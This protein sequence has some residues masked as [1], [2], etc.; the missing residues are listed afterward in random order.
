M[1]F[2][3]YIIPKLFKCIDDY[4]IP[5]GY[6]NWNCTTLNKN[7]NGNFW[8]ITGDINIRYSLSELHKLSV[9]LHEIGHAFYYK[10]YPNCKSKASIIKFHNTISENNSIFHNH[11]ERIADVLGWKILLRLEGEQELK[12]YYV[13]YF[14][15]RK[16][17]L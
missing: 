16:D 7:V 4:K 6:V 8:A 11:D 13:N 15:T 5:F 12:N 9:F 10:L 3:T 1:I 17:E 14:L 2:N